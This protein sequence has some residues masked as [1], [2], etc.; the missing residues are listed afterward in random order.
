MHRRIRQWWLKRRIARVAEQ[1]DGIE[2]ARNTLAY[3]ERL[4]IAE[5]SRLRSE[6]LNLD[7]RSRRAPRP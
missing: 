6:L 4:F 1:L 5:A 3:H 2:H 7:I